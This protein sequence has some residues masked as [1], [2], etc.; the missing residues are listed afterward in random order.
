MGVRRTVLG[1]CGAAALAMGLAAAAAGDRYDIVA[2]EPGV[3]TPRQ[4]LRG[5]QDRPDTA[6][7]QPLAPSARPRVAQ[8]PP[9]VLPNGQIVPSLPPADRG[10]A[11]GGGAESF[12]DRA[13]R[14]AHQSGLYGVPGEQRHNYMHLCT[15]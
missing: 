10:L 4:P 7:T 6:W 12:G 2:P 8:P 9:I 1:T 15:Q 13:A 3:V 14:C 5:L 11:P